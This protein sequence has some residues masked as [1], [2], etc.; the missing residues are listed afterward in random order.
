MYI[1]TYNIK[2]LGGIFMRKLLLFLFLV[3]IVVFGLSACDSNEGEVDKNESDVEAKTGED[4]TPSSKD[5][6]ET[7]ADEKAKEDDHWTY[8][9]D[10]TWESDFNGLVTKI[11][12]VVATEEGPTIEDEDAEE[13]IIGVKFNIENTTDD[14][15]FDTYPDQAELVTSTGEQV[16]AEMFLSDHI[17]GNIDKGVIKEGDVFSTLNVERL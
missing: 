14:N 6:K 13:S 11:E 17:G 2:F 3:L 10:A 12:K 5:E 4:G 9:E 15:E 7:E 8:Y 16:D 1:I